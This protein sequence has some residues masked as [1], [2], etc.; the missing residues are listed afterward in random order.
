MAS[1]NNLNM[2]TN[3]NIYNDIAQDVNFVSVYGKLKKYC[4]NTCKDFAILKLAFPNDNIRMLYEESIKKHNES[5]IQ[6]IHCDSGFDLFVPENVVFQNTTKP[7][8]IDM[9][10]KAEMV[11]CDLST[12]N[13]YPSAYYLYPRSSLSK[14]ELMMANHLGVIDSGYRGSLIGAFRWIN[15]DPYN[16]TVEY[17]TRLVQICNPN[18]CPFYILVVSEEELTDTERG[19]GGF[20]STGL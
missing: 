9:K 2:N 15:P 4:K 6:N 16:Y 8:F 3:N 1:F 14:T 5:F 19:I 13:I 18:L 12:D 10:V 11:H 20:G 17:K 7:T